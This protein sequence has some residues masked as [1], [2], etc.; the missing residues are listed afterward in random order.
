MHMPNYRN[1]CI[2]NLMSSIAAKHGA[3]LP[4]AQLSKNYS[5]AISSSS[6]TLLLVLDGL[7]YEFIKEFGENSTFKKYLM[8]AMTSVFPSTTSASLNSF[9]T[10]L[11]PQQHA[12]TG[13]FM[14]LKELGIVSK[15][16]PFC[17]RIGGRAFSEDGVN[18]Q[19]IFENK[20]LFD[21]LP[22]DTHYITHESFINSDFTLATAGAACRH[23]YSGISGLFDTITNVAN[24]CSNETYTYAYWPR[25]D[26]ICHMHGVHD[27]KAIDH[28][29]ELDFMF[30]SLLESLDGTDT[31]IIATSDH[32]LIDVGERDT[33]SLDEHPKLA[34]TL[35]L[36]LCGEARAAY[37]YVRPSKTD[38]FERYV[39]QN[40][41]YCC[42]LFPS[43]ELVKKGFFGLFEPNKKLY[44]RI[45]D[46]V[47]IM[48][49]NYI[50]K[51]QLQGEDNNILKAYHGGLSREEMLIPLIVANV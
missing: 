17:P 29:S 1:G 27:K 35:A 3:C 11:T 39:T 23:S 20:P 50:I 5:K 14:Y 15:I 26:T 4:Y 8:G 44:D 43:E 31:T 46:Y 33:V 42:D 45:G 40:L 6:N 24:S 41:S 16:L 12:I 19:D 34:S 21:I 37:C 51:D 2:V 18:P 25:F 32:G 30:S 38:A 10:G 9:A 36:P 22:V 49:D 7:G 13:W 47:L 48:K 28:F